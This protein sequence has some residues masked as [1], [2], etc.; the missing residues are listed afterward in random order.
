MHDRDEDETNG[1]D[2]D[3]D[4]SNVDDNGAV[5]SNSEHSNNHD[6]MSDDT[7]KSREE[8]SN[9]LIKSRSRTSIVQ[10]LD[11]PMSI[12]KP[13][14]VHD[15]RMAWPTDLETK[16]NDDFQPVASPLASICLNPKAN[17]T[18]RPVLY[19]K[20]REPETCQDRLRFNVAQDIRSRTRW[21]SQRLFRVVSAST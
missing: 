20:Q 16:N 4:E 7:D 15:N 9:K 5:G 18:G 10:A 6:G 2:R 14:E 11:T 21:L 19:R 1:E 13:Q 8:H 3:E 12:T 17:K